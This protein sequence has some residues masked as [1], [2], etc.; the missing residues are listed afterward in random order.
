MD[1]TPFPE[2]TTA[3]MDHDQLFKRLFEA[4]LQEFFTL[5][6]PEIAAPLDFSQVRFHSQEVLTDIPYGDRNLLDVV[7]ELGSAATGGRVVIL[8]A[9]VEHDRRARL[10][11]EMFDIYGGC[12]SGFGGPSFRSPST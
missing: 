3:R 5:L 10:L 1:P 7:A 11:E 8:H 12:G 4:F 6:R 2:T 9:E